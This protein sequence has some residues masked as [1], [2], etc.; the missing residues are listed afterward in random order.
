MI[1]IGAERQPI[2]LGDSFPASEVVVD[3]DVR[4]AA[5]KVKLHIPYPS[6]TDN[7]QRLLGIGLRE[8]RIVRR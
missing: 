7:D 4:D 3:F 8:I 1:E 2:V 6:G 5:E